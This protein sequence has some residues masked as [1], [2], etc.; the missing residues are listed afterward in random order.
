MF[1]ISKL[2]VTTISL[3]AL[4][5]SS[6]ANILRYDSI[7]HPTSV[8]SDR[9]MV[10]AQEKIASQVG[11]NILG[12]GGNAI[13]AAV[14]TGFALAVTYPQAGNIGG[15]GF[16]LIHLAKENKTIAL[17]YR[18]MAPALAY[19]DLFL[20]DN[21]DVDNQ[22]ARF[23]ALATAVPGSVKGLVHAQ[24]RYGKL[25]LKQVMQPAIDLALNGF[26]I[27]PTQAFS[28]QRVSKRLKQY[29]TSSQYFLKGDG[30]SY[31]E[32]ELFKQPVLGETLQRVAETNGDDFYTGKTAKLL[33]EE[34]ER[35]GGIM[36]LEDLKNYRVVERKPLTGNYRGYT[37]V[38]MPPP[39]SGGVHIVQMLNILQ[40]W[41]LK[42]L[43]SNSSE[44]LHRLIEVMKLAYVDRS[45]YLGDSDFFP[46]PIEKLTSKEY[47][48]ALFNRINLEKAKRSKE[49]EPGLGPLNGKDW[50]SST[51]QLIRESR[52]TTHFNVFD[53]EGNVVAN[54][55]TLNFS[56]GNGIAVSGAGFLLNN[57]MDDFSAKPGAPNGYGLVGAEANAIEAK[58]R[59]LSSMSPSIVLKGKQPI[60]AVGAPGG[61]RI[62]T[63]TLQTII[64]VI[65]FEMN[66]AEAIATPRIH[67]QW[68]PDV[69]ATEKGLSPDTVVLLQDKGHILRPTRWTIGKVQGIHWNN[70]RLSGFSDPRWPDGGVGVEPD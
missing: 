11:A 51:Y 6:H 5:L 15:G 12:M 41:D 13:D 39:S 22:K 35:Q 67:H 45:V 57:E 36:T 32:G 4:V 30:T 23:S 24:Q 66:I 69:V 38:S 37:V 65:D 42:S 7:H 25:T 56:Y 28:F 43:G 70:G 31:T 63:S 58:K 27:S 1:Y 17:D 14:A 61:S 2:I 54:T 26:S 44:Y 33:I 48:T 55:Y 10:V 64:N 34:I 18:E 40:H 62:I 49:M 29:K 50:D 16:M 9:G 20:D 59:P 19:R 52:Q 46:V 8:N 21:G 60:L 53:K 68:L 3:L 47:A